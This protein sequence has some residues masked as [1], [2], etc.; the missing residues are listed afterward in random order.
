M[1]GLNHDLDAGLAQALDLTVEVFAGDVERE[2][3]ADALAGAGV[4]LALHQVQLQG[5]DDVPLAGE[6]E[7]GAVDGLQTQL[8]SVEVAR[9]FDVRHT[10]RDVTVSGYGCHL[11]PPPR[12]CA[13][14][15]ESGGMVQLLHVADR[16]LYARLVG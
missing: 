1:V 8:L 6:A 10:D 15:G 14:A 16:R 3:R 2:V 12:P 4:V 9:L 5:A 13:C 11:E 7:V